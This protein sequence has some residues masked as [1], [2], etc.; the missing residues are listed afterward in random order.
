LAT[1]RH[2]KNKGNFHITPTEM[3]EGD[4]KIFRTLASGDYWQCRIKVPNEQQYFRRSLK[5]KNLTEAKDKAKELY[6]DVLAKKRSGEAIFEQTPDQ[7]VSLY[8]E[9]ELRSVEFGEKK[10]SRVKTIESQ[11]KH[12]LNF[13]SNRKLSSIQTDEFRGYL[14]YR[15]NV[16]V[17][18]KLSTVINESSSIKHFYKWAIK[19]GKLSQSTF[20]EFPRYQSPK[21]LGET[22]DRNAISVEDWRAIYRYLRG[23]NKYID[24]GHEKSDR[25]KVRYFIHLL[26]NSG[27][28]FG[29][30]LQLKWNNVVVA[31]NN[32]DKFESKM[33]IYVRLGKT[34]SRTT[35]S[36][37]GDIIG[38]IKKVSKFTEPNDFIFSDN[39]TGKPIN[40]AR[41]YKYWREILEQTGLSNSNPKP[42]YY[43]LRHTYATWRLYAGVDVFTLSQLMGTSIA[44]IEDHYGH[45]DIHKKAD[46]ILKNFKVSEDGDIMVD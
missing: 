21:K 4:V 29:E 3:F 38:K 8:L 46:V 19:T 10:L 35:I 17:D 5:T 24:D 45:I 28:R 15:R 33:T 1:K 32:E 36:R 26:L 42:V 27:L 11:L 43:S 20:P 23:W 16:Q 34:G 12:F 14:A 25:I 13:V 37:R 2:R 6:L 30:A 39:E 22:T 44:N 18:V 31:I 41:L 9:N 40:K 7:L